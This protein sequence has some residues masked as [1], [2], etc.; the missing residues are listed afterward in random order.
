MLDGTFHKK[1]LTRSSIPDKSATTT[2]CP[3]GA[4][5]ELR[6]ASEGLGLPPIRG[7]FCML[8]C[9]PDQRPVV[10]APA[11]LSGTGSLPLQAPP[12]L[13]NAC[14]RVS[15]IVDF[16]SSRACAAA[17]T[18]GLGWLVSLVNASSVLASACVCL[19]GLVG[20]G[21]MGTSMPRDSSNSPNFLAEAS[22]ERTTSSI[23]SPD[24][25]ASAAYWAMPSVLASSCR[26]LRLLSRSI[27][28]A[29]STMAVSSSNLGSTSMRVVMS[30]SS[31]SCL[32]NLG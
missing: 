14:S 27:D 11:Y 32:G 7:R 6:R 24:S 17:A 23:D 9:S 16:T 31:S 26:D 13:R 10:S 18:S 12:A 20:E 25:S 19:A 3:L 8:Y 22:C 2:M 30:I 21:F 28:R 5:S 15:R 29:T 1:W 4:L